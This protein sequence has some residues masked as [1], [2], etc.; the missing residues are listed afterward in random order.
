MLRPALCPHHALVYRS[1]GR[2][3]RELPLRVS[4]IG[5]MYRAERSGVLGGLSRVR[6]IT[7]N[8]AHNFCAL[9]QVGQEVSEILRLIRAAHAA[10]GVRPAGYG[11]RCAGRG[12]VRRRRRAVGA[13]RG[14]APRRPRRGAVHRGVR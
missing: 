6:A 14:S 2:S 3:Y 7:L 9:E 13:G 4:E 5:G 11:C 1:R 8:D 10:L 12:E